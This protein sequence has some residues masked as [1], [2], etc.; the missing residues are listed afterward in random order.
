MIASL[1]KCE[2]KPKLLWNTLLLLP[3]QFLV[4]FDWFRGH[5]LVLLGKTKPP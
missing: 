1:L 3:P 4:A 2:L 5:E